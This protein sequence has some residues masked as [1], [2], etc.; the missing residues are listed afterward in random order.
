[1]VVVVDYMGNI[2]DL[3]AAMKCLVVPLVAPEQVVNTAVV[4]AGLA[5]AVVDVERK[6]EVF[7]EVVVVEGEAKAAHHNYNSAD[8]VACRCV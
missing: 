2:A 3:L 4:A 1:M 6:R 5:V 7:V 8:K